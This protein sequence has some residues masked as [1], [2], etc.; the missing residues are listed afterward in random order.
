LS[1]ENLLPI[2]Y[3]NFENNFYKDLVD[4]PTQSINYRSLVISMTNVRIA[5]SIDIVHSFASYK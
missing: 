4:Y 2:R 5:I 1:N 3:K